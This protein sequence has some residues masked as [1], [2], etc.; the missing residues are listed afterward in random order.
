M[1]VH[2]GDTLLTDREVHL[3]LGS[4]WTP[5]GWSLLIPPTEVKSLTP[6]QGGA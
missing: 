4:D 1:A 5:A 3:C 2:G 6:E